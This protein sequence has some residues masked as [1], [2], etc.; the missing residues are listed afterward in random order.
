[1]LVELHAVE[2]SEGRWDGEFGGPYGVRPIH[3]CMTGYA[4]MHW[5][6]VGG[7]FGGEDTRSLSS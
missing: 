6:P 1:M 5:L 7:L 2:T 4:V 3:V